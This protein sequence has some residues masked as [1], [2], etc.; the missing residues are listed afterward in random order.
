MR[1]KPHQPNRF[2][3]RQRVA[4]WL[5]AT[6]LVMFAL[7]ALFNGAVYLPS[8]RGGVMLS[9]LPTLL[10]ALASL[11]MATA[12]ISVVVDHH[13]RRPNEAA[14]RRTRKRLLGAAGLLY[15][16]APLVE[17]LAPDL[18]QSVRWH[19]SVLHVSPSVART[20]LELLPASTQAGEHVTWA[21]I[22]LLLLGWLGQRTGTASG[23]RVGLVS[24]GMALALLG[25]GCL[26]KV[27]ES[28]A[29]GQIGHQQ[30]T[31][32]IMT[33]AS[34]QPEHF[35]A[36]AATLLSVALTVLA[37]GVFFTLGG[38]FLRLKTSP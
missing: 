19:T 11:A 35:Y 31:A 5:V 8:R 18:A 15:L 37:T 2:A 3:R 38:L 32:Q 25:G 10:I 33:L 27:M 26:V 24:F 20:W 4:S 12:A 13:D 30:G 1:P 7:S 9:G 17:H 29:Q 6:L 22:G 28:V 23:T 14:Y 21:L 16:L 36:V 34:L